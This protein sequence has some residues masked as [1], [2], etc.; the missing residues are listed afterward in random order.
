M[1]VSIASE[2][3]SVSD[4]SCWQS[5]YEMIWATT[6]LC[7]RVLRV[8]TALCVWVGKVAGSNVALLTGFVPDQP[9]F[10]VAT[11]IIGTHKRHPLP[12]PHWQ[13]RWVLR[14]EVIHC[15]QRS[16][17]DRGCVV[18]GMVTLLLDVSGRN[19]L[20]LISAIDLRVEWAKKSFTQH[21]AAQH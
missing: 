5:P 4:Q 6:A 16:F 8:A 13:L 3:R 9:P 18:M 12:F 10:L 15:L 17:H 14:Y 1:S 2:S 11:G 20:K 7:A 21:Q 19:F